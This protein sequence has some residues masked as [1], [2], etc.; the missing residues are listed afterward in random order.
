MAGGGMTSLNSQTRHLFQLAAKVCSDYYPE[1]MGNTFVANAP[2]SFTAIWAICKGFLDEKTRK[3]IKI[4][5]GSFKTDLLEFLDDENIPDFLGGKCTCAALGGCINSNIGPWND[6]ELTATGIRR[7]GS[8]ATV[9]EVK[10]ED[11]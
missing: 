2:F 7:K 4:C 6:F 5:G 1:T 11:P 9:E 10:T 8:S 3:K